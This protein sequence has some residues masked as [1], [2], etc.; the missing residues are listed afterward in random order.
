MGLQRVRDA[1]PA[2][3]D[4]D[5]DNDDDPLAGVQRMSETLVER[6]DR[7]ASAA[8]QF[9]VF[10]RSAGPTADAV[11]PGAA[12]TEHLPGLA[13]QTVARLRWAIPHELSGV[14]CGLDRDTL[15]RVVDELVGNADRALDGAPKGYIWLSLKRADDALV[16]R[17]EDNGPGIPGEL[18]ADLFDP[19]FSVTSTETGL[20]LPIAKRLVGLCG[21]RLSLVPG[22]E[23]GAVF[24]LR[25]PL[26]E[27][28]TVRAPRDASAVRAG[29]ER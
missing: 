29:S 27:E 26:V 20:G 21:G 11:A 3:G 12:L 17:V 6:V 7:L 13:R 4:D 9:R 2:F 23:R 15:L 5:E 1:R 28:E 18:L 25:L 22:Q 10:S 19:T 8:E 24:E 14:R 16:L